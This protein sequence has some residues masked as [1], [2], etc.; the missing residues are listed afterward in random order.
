MNY[1]TVLTSG[2]LE[3]VVGTPESLRAAAGDRQ[4]FSQLLNA[5]IPADWPHEF[6]DDALE[7]MAALLEQEAR[8]GVERGIFTFWFIILKEPRTLIGTIGLKGAP[9]EEAASPSGLANQAAPK[10][11]I[12]AGRVDI[13]YG[14]VKSHQRRG[15]AREAVR[16][17][18]REVFADPRVRTVVGETLEDLH[19]S[20]RVLESCGF[21][22]TAAGQTGYSGEENV[23]R[24]DLPRATWESMDHSSPR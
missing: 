6:L 19:A 22:R 12:E 15:Y 3:M 24:Y 17:M 5:V 23:V 16:R 18:L 10:I 14:L 2:R 20:I 13:G 9:S 11:E 4:W 21:K 7:P 8:C 1:T